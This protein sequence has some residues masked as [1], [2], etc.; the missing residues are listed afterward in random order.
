[1][2]KQ[3][4]TTLKEGFSHRKMNVL[5]ALL[6]G[7]VIQIAGEEYRYAMKDEELYSDGDRVFVAT[8]EG[9]FKSC[10][11][12]SIS[13]GISKDGTTWIRVTDSLSY[14]SKLIDN[15]SEDEIMISLA[16]K[17]LTSFNQKDR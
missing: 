16:N 7:H 3:T 8:E 5:N 17:A 14:I 2:S 13:N 15:M 1:M 9:I 4:I 11:V 6:Q 10:S 12:Q